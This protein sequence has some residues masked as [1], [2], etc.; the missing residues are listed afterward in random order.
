MERTARIAV[1]M[2]CHNR[3][4]LT[5]ACLETLRDQPL[6]RPGDLFLV[7]DGSTDGTGDAV[8]AAMPEAQVIAGDGALF[9]NG[10]MRWAWDAAKAA[11]RPFE[12]YLWLNDDV[13]LA[14]G[15]LDMLVADADATAPR[16]SPVIVSA[17]TSDPVSGAITYG[18]HGPPDPVRL[19][20]AVLAP[21]GH[22]IPAQSISGN[23]VL[24]SAAAEALL[25]NLTPDFE[26]IFGD[27]DYGRRANAQGIPVVLASRIGG[28][29]A[30]NRASGTSHDESLGLVARLRLHRQQATGAH[31]RDWRRFV[32]RY[33]AGR[34]VSLRHR[35]VP[36]LR[37]LRSWLRHR[38]AGFISTRAG[39]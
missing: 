30:A 29:C 4:A 33:G 23:V 16:G 26:H 8:R 31:G 21:V 14:P 38:A 2:T 27:L 37:I 11:G 36:Y 20:G 34:L 3:R 1:L 5:L 35:V 39:T 25:G 17:A 10:G 28:L 19:L 24:V 15:A 12:F 13:A 18:A 32:R 7:D 9:W 6:F 22:P